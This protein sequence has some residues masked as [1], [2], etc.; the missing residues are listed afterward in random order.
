[1]AKEK[2]TVK[3]IRRL[4]QQYFRFEGNPEAQRKLEGRLATIKNTK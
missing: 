2:S 4:E 1:M 3:K